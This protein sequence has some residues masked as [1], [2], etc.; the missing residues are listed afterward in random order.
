MKFGAMN[1]PVRP[2]V[3]EI[4]AVAQMG[5]DFVEMA[6][7]P[8][9]CHFSR[10]KE[11]RVSIMNTLREQELDL[12]CHMPTFVHTADLAQSI[13][14]AS[15]AEIINSL[16]AAADLESSKIVL[17][18]G[19]IKGMALHVLDQA[20]DLA[21]ESL[22]QIARR[23]REVGM[24]VC[25]ENMFTGTGPF[26]EPADFRPVFESFPEFR[27]VLDIGHAHIGD[28]RGDRVQRFIARWGDRLAHLHVSDNNG[29]R[30]QHLPL[31]EGSLPL[32]R[33]AEALKRI[34][35]DG[36]VTLEVFGQDSRRIIE[37]RERLMNLINQLS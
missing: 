27:L 29:E 24:Q 11:Q 17:H 33:T 26:I 36:T 31:G 30:D 10:I 25:I 7:D 12:V 14:C 34:G 22:A 4:V 6:M 2:V 5:M 28:D 23:A 16:E 35:Y 20:M 9:Q 18:P 32:E 37:S 15:V 13:R 8:P 21:M 1:F 3:S 19:V